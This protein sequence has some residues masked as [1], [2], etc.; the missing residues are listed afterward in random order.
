VPD[1][2]T[3]LLDPRLSPFAQSELTWTW[4]N[5]GT[6]WCA[7]RSEEKATP[8]LC[9]IGVVATGA[10]IMHTQECANLILDQRLSSE[11]F[12]AEVNEALF[13]ED[14]PPKLSDQI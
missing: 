13:H 6:S 14:P 5:V 2:A 3:D 7:K 11:R 10:F 4:L 8:T 1:I 9:L 12:S